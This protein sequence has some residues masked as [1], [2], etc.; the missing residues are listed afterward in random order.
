MKKFFLLLVMIFGICNVSYAT[1]SGDDASNIDYAESYAEESLDYDLGLYDDS[2]TSDMKYL[3]LKG[4]VEEVGEVFEEKN[5]YY[6][7]SYQDVKVHIKDQG[8]NTTK[9][10]RHSLSFY[11]GIEEM[12]KPLKKG[13]KVIVHATISSDGKIQDTAISERDNT[14]YLVLILVIYSLAIVIIG[15]KK[16]VK[17]LVSLVITILAIFY[18][19]LPK[20]IEGVNP[21]GI[22]TIVSIGITIIVL[23]IIAGFNKKAVAAILGT[24]GGIL[25]AGIFAIIFGN[26]M[27]L[28]GI[29]EEAGTLSQQVLYGTEEMVKYDFKGLMYAGIIIGALG[30]C[31]D[32]SMSIASA[33]HELKEENNEISVRRMLSA[34]MNIGKDMMGTMT[35]T[36]ILAYMGC[37]MVLVMLLTVTG[38]NLRHVI[39]SEMILEEVLSAI[40][41]SFGLVTTIPF[42]TL[43]TSL[44][45]GKR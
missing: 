22:T 43:V 1:E 2:T 11:T 14:N 10:I 24:T 8:Y 18:I 17:A 39:N 45:M 7:F 6:T 36:L 31:M 9:I 37:S 3:Y 32:V 25:I 30:A 34:G 29:S 4:T 40:A 41:G 16:G 13:D 19:I 20:L 23:F 21:L 44:L 27:D 42:T 35:N 15:G 28:S 26:L 5:D 12:S 33:L 38:E